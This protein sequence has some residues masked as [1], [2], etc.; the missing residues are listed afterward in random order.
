[1]KKTLLSAAL[2]CLTIVQPAMAVPL[3]TTELPVNAYI[4]IGNYDVA[5]ISPLSQYQDADFSVQ[6]AYGWRRMTKA[7]YDQIGGLTAASFAFDGANVDVATGNNLDEASG[8]SVEGFTIVPSQDVA[9]ASPWFSGSYTWVDWDQGL[10]AE[11]S[12]ADMDLVGLDG[13][14][15]CMDI[16]N[17]SLAYRIHGG[18]K[19]PEP[20]TLALVGLGLA[21]AGWRRRP[22]R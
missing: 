13:A 17:E 16:C 15:G 6:S 14:S 7:I 3:V 1:M 20:A 21:A 22:A 19:L 4:T 2:A 5:W 9:V 10:N 18:N 11:W 8:A 12:L